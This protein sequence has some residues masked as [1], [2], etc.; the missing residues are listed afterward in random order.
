MGYGAGRGQ[1]RAGCTRPVSLDQI[2]VDKIRNR[3]TRLQLR[4]TTPLQLQYRPPMTLARIPHQLAVAMRS[5]P[6]RTSPFP[7]A[8]RSLAI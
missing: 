1:K 5:Y 8:V 6:R 7:I 3:N 2:L 4:H